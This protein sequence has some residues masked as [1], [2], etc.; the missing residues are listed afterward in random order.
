MGVG[1]RR[2]HFDAVLANTRSVAWFEVIAENYVGFGGRA[3]RVL[4]HCLAQV[5]VIAHGVSTSI[6]GRDRYDE[7]WIAGLKSFLGRI[8]AP[9]FSEHLCWSAD[10]GWV[11]HD[12]LPLPFTTAAA[13]HVGRRTAELADRLELPI[14]LENITYY[15]NMPSSVLDEGAFVTEV[16]ERSGA[17]LLLDVNNVYVN[18]INHGRDPEEVLCSLP[19][20]RVRQIH[21][22]GHRT[23]NGLLI[24]DHSGPVA[25]PVMGLLA[26]ALERT[27][28]V[29]ILLEWDQCLPRLDTLIDEVDRVVQFVTARDGLRAG[30]PRPVNHGSRP[31]L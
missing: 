29:P 3:F 10:R 8:S 21:V 27:G 6:G 28:P 5:P 1:L 7:H 15:A 25:A 14:L 16:L 24:D 17:G 26:S 18:A 31:V 4:E 11:S 9:F 22:A 13:Q 30:D 2:D 23:E 12:L 20:G 19:L